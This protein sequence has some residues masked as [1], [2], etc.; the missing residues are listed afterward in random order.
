MEISGGGEEVGPKGGSEFFYLGG[1]QNFSGPLLRD[2]KYIVG[3]LS[4]SPVHLPSF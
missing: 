4:L 2:F 1:L 3:I